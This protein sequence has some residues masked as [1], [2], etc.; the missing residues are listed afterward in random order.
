[1]NRSFIMLESAVAALGLLVTATMANAQVGCNCQRGYFSYY[2]SALPFGY[3]NSVAPQRGVVLPQ[4]PTYAPDNPT[5]RRYDN[6]GIPDFQLG[7]R[8]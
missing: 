4:T 3:Y 6:P 5:P 1:M 7:S 2:N 8:G